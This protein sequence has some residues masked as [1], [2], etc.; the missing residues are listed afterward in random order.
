[1]DRITPEVRDEALADPGSI[2]GEAT[3]PPEA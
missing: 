1:M 2:P 3:A